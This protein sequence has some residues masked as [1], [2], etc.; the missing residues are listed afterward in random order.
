[1]QLPSATNTASTTLAS[2]ASAVVVAAG[3]G[4]PF[5]A[6]AAAAL[7]MT[8]IGVA[9]LLGLGAYA[10]VNFATTHVAEVKD[11]DGMVQTWWPRIEDTY[12]TGRNGQTDTQPQAGSNIGQK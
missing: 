4:W 1:M 10:V 8:P 5:V 9:G 6:T 3:P 7:G 11:L 12:P 2:L